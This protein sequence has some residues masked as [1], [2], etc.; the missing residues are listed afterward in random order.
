PPPSSPDPHAVVPRQQSYDAWEAP[1]PADAEYGTYGADQ[2]Y[3]D[4]AYPAETYEPAPQEPYRAQPHQ[5]GQYDPY[6]S[7]PS[8]D[9]PQPP[10][11]PHGTD[12]ERPDG[13]RQ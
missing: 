1:A 8:Y 9:Q 2:P 10:M 5:G 13:S 6:A 4:G 12:S 3:Q 11:P 7:Y